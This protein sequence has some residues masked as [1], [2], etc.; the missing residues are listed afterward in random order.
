MRAAVYAGRYAIGADI[1]SVARAALAMPLPPDAAP[2]VNDLLLDGLAAWI[3]GEYSVAAARLRTALAALSAAPP[4]EASLRSLE[5]GCWAAV[6]LGDI[7]SASALSRTLDAAAREQGAW[8]NVASAL[9]YMEL[10][11]LARGAIVA[12]GAHAA[13]ERELESTRSDT[14]LHSGIPL[15]QAWSGRESEVRD[16]VALTWREAPGMGRGRTLTCTDYAAALLE[17]GLGNYTEARLC[18]PPDW[19][20]DGH[21]AAFAAADYVEAAARGGDL[22]AAL[23]AVERFEARAQAA[24]TPALLG[25]LA[26]CQALVAAGDGVESLYLESIARLEAATAEAEVAR[27]RLLYGEWLR[28]VNRALDAREQ[29]RMAFDTFEAI[30]ARCFAERARAELS[31]AGGRARRSDRPSPTELTPQEEQVA[32]MAAKGATNVEI[33]GRLFISPNTVDYHLRKV[34][35]KL[36]ITSWRQLRARARNCSHLTGRGQEHRPMRQRAFCG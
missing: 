8:S 32:Q 10:M 31:V 23:S 33:A 3:V 11:D 28:R 18:F 5:F 36:G 6:Y 27:S 20:R 9:H 22:P 24:N 35:R 13:E 15:A 17:L 7:E 21:L 4:G 14:I 19:E 30:G 26:R 12:V 34:Y 16:L 2:G 29:L 25:L 1:I